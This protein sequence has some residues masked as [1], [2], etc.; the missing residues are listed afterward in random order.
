GQVAVS[1]EG[2]RRPGQRRGGLDP[3]AALA[4]QPEEAFGLIAEADDGRPVGHEAAE[5]GPGGA[6]MAD[7]EGGGLPDAFQGEGDVELVGADGPHPYAVVAG[8]PGRRRADMDL[9]APLSQPAGVALVEVVDGDVA[10]VGL[11]ETDRRPPGPQHGADLLG[12]VG[13]HEPPA[14]TLE[15]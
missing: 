1:N 2:G 12:L 4:G 13:R 15:E 7:G 6:D 5:P 11:E 3:E 9:A 14:V 10:G 8:Q